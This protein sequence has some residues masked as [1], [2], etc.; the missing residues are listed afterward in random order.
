MIWKIRNL[1]TD[2]GGEY[3]SNDFERYLTI[4][5]IVHQTTAAYSPASN[6]ISERANRRFLEPMRCMLR[7]AGIVT[8]D[9]SDNMIH[10]RCIF[11]E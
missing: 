6:G 11:Q 4:E 10:R 1:R 3:C 9:E 2:G 8:P 7:Q 5:E